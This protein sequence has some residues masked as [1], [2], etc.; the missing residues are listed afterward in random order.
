LCGGLDIKE[1]EKK[2]TKKGTGPV[3][4]GGGRGYGPPPL[5]CQC[6]RQ[7]ESKIGLDD[8]QCNAATPVISYTVV[9]GGTAI[10]QLDFIP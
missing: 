3:R 8:I 2:E 9:N 5:P 1:Q 6:I 4:M 7:V 10:S